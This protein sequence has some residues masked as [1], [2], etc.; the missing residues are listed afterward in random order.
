M[1]WTLINIAIQM[2][3]GVFGAQAAAVAM[4]EHSFGF[5]GHTIAGALAGA[6]S[7]YF[8]QGLAVTMVTGA[9]T[10]NEP[11]MVENAILQGLT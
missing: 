4:K 3:A 10:I 5:L 9:D 6:F 11:T 7:G 8:L 2:I 1:N